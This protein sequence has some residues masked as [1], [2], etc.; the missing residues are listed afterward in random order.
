MKQK[1]LANLKPWPKEYSDAVD[2][3]KSINQEIDYYTGLRLATLEKYALEKI[4][5]KD[6][7]AQ[8]NRIDAKLEDLGDDKKD[9][10]EYVKD[11]EQIIDEAMQLINQPDEF[12]NQ[13]NLKIQK[14]IQWLIFP[15][16]LE[17]DFGT[18]FGTSPLSQT[19]L[20]IQE[21]NKKLPENA[22][23]VQHYRAG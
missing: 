2:N 3:A 8:I 6:M 10:D 23:V 4:S 13:A 12:W 9:A 16:G 20:L 19:H 1:S 7:Q 11:K 21:L 14:A 22:N 5:E 18:G 15:N 17:Y